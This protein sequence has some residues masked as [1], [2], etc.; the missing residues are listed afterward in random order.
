MGGL[1]FYVGPPSTDLHR[2]GGPS[3]DGLGNGKLIHHYG[4]VWADDS[5]LFGSCAKENSRRPWWCT[6]SAIRHRAP[7]RP[8]SQGRT[9]I[10]WASVP[11]RRV[12]PLREGCHG[13]QVCPSIWH[14]ATHRPGYAR[15]R[16]GGNCRHQPTP[17]Q[18]PVYIS[19]SLP[20]SHRGGGRD[21]DTTGPARRTRP[22]GPVANL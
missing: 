22:D 12:P 19:P 5:L 14:C 11:L 4:L 18:G 17:Q 9:C 10:C 8:S 2:P 3:T 1:S 20:A 6:P 15:M 7:I 21:H 13:V 16:R